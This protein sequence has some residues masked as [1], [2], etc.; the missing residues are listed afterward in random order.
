[1]NR[2]RILITNITLSSRSGTELYTRDLAL[3]L[4]ELGHIPMVFS[5]TLGKLAEALRQAG[6]EVVRDVA[7]IQEP[8]DAIHGHH[9][10][11]TMAAL[12]QFPGVPAVFFCHDFSAWHD[13][14]PQFPRIR[15]YVAV[16]DAC[17]ERLSNCLNLELDAI[18]VLQN[19]V[20]LRRFRCRKKIRTQPKSALVFSNY[21]DH[22]HLRAIRIATANRGI[23]LDC[24]G[25]KIGG[26]SESPQTLLHQ[27][28]IVF[29]KGR[30]AWEAIATGAAVIVSDAD[31]LGSMV[32]S[33][34]LE[35][36]RRLNFG[37]RLLRGSPTIE[38]VEH[39]LDRYDPADITEVTKRVRTMA[40][41]DLRASQLVDLYRKV[42]AEQKLALVNPIEDLRAT[43]QFLNWWS[44]MRNQLV[45]ERAKNKRWPQ[46]LK[47]IFFNGY[48]RFAIK[49][50][51]LDHSFAR[52]RKPIRFRKAA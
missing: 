24:V 52:L 34:E 41:L 48:R 35:H 18:E 49:Y 8:P 51:A 14:P 2:L 44:V 6:V 11:E 46:V 39:Q 25:A 30:C 7:E 3:K 9:C 16:D 4:L 38:E 37:R 15:R 31:G 26:V 12:L 33:S 20:D 21:V 50:P 10:L 17:R 22:R 19:A 1:M 28:D 40:D 45:R 32:T 23:S 47:R 13:S 43:A 36:L 5:P 29:A 42:I 27:Y